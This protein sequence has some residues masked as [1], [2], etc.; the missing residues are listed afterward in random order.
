MFD[1][2]NTRNWV[3][4]AFK[5]RRKCL[6][7]SGCPGQVEETWS[8]GRF[9][10]AG[11]SVVWLWVRWG[12]ERPQQLMWTLTPKTNLLESLTQL[13]EP[14]GMYIHL[15][16][17]HAF[18]FSAFPFCG[19]WNWLNGTFYRKPHLTW[20]FPDISSEQILDINSLRLPFLYFDPTWGSLYFRVKSSEDC[21]DSHQS[22]WLI[23][24]IG[25]S[26]SVHGFHRPVMVAWHGSVGFSRREK[27]H[28]RPR[29][30]K[31]DGKRV[32][33]RIILESD[34]PFLSFL[35]CK[36]IIHI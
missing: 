24:L 13:A 2:P 32:V 1:D 5:S 16:R 17:C 7:P 34:C 20:H 21:H 15:L 30:P 9:L 26:F 33:N 28:C 22:L 29:N 35:V 6:E 25:R 8:V 4:G 27:I 3:L 36:Y 23:G 11:P 12:H 14:H 10:A 18:I 31:I 19:S